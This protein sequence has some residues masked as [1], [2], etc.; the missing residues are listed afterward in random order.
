MKLSTKILFMVF[1]TNFVL[2]IILSVVSISGIN[3]IGKSDIAQFRKDGTEMKKNE[4]KQLVELAYSTIVHYH[5]LVENGAIDIETGKELAKKQLKKSLYDGGRGYF[6][7]ND[8]G[9][10]YP[11]MVMHSVSS[12]L[13]GKILDNPKY[14]CAMGKN[15]NLFSAMVEVCSK[16]GE[17]FVD[18]IWPD[19]NDKTKNLPKLSYVKLFSEWEWIIGTG[20]YIDDID[21]I[22]AKKEKDV[23][24]SVGKNIL[25]NIIVT[26]IAISIGLLA[27]F[28]I[29]KAISNSINIIAVDIGKGA[30]HV[31]TASHQVS[32]SSQ[33][34]AQGA[35]EQ[36]SGLQEITSSIEELSSMTKQNANNANEANSMGQSANNAGE[37]SKLDVGEMSSAVK[38]IK[39]SSDETA[40]IIKSIDEIA[41][42]TNLLALNAA[43][44][45]A[46]AGDAGRGFAVVADEVRNLA[47]RSAEAARNTTLLIEGMIKTSEN[48]VKATTKVEKSISE[49]TDT[50]NKMTNL[51][52][53]V[54]TAS[55]E[56]AQGLGQISIA[57][58]E[59]DSITQQ[60]AATSEESASA[61]EELSAQAQG[62][63]ESV[64][65]LRLIIGEKQY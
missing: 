40:Q 46:R 63:N 9:K 36:A 17:G 20:V 10:P 48:G 52:G 30:E 22:V 61:S 42:Q 27:A 59:L 58:G 16:E 35:N 54:S 43:V 38:S 64:D 28:G 62:L 5:S 33:Q 37:Q 4:L 13:E 2:A 51:L 24:E 47:Q 25:F 21:K 32:S 60:N 15:Q 7:I 1:L 31:E 41:M 39:K 57:I 12:Q 55:S 45:A 19:P 18:Y 11:K 49:M 14:D 44:E 34:L 50:I 56:Q 6:W 53:E 65:A 23:S 8:T 29:A 3:N 26:S